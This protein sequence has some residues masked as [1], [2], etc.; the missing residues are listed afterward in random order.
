M[1]KWFVLVW[2]MSIASCLNHRQPP[3]CLHRDCWTN[4]DSHICVRLA[5]QAEKD[6]FDAYAKQ[7]IYERVYYDC[8][9]ARGYPIDPEYWIRAKHQSRTLK[10]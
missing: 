4:Q 7:A 6:V 5:E 3:E 9:G 10:R 1:K 8:M 2:I